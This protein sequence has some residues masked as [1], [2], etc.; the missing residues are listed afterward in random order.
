MDGVLP[1][2][3]RAYP[4]GILL[5][6]SIAIDVRE[7]FGTREGYLIWSDANRLTI[8][9]MEFFDAMYE[10]TLLKSSQIG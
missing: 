7:S 1:I 10:I 8:L 2:D 4:D 9:I 5:K 3:H 6:V